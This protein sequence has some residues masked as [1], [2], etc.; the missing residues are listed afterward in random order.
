MFCGASPPKLNSLA[1]IRTS[2]RF[3]TQHTGQRAERAPPLTEWKQRPRFKCLFADT[4]SRCAHPT[5]TLPQAAEML[6]LPGAALLLLL[7]VS[8]SVDQAAA[9]VSVTLLETSVFVFEKVT[10][11]VRFFMRFITILTWKWLQPCF[12]FLFFLWLRRAATLLLEFN[13]N[14]M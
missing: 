9:E 14:V 4:R 10:K 2:Y 13:Y 6:L 1:L 5:T 12:L 3:W 8:S 7:A 11:Y